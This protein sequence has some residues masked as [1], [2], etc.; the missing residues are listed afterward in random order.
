MEIKE[1]KRKIHKRIRAAVI[2]TAILVGLFAGTRWFLKR[3]GGTYPKGVY[4][5][6]ALCQEAYTGTDT[7]PDPFID[8]SGN[9]VPAG[10]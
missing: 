5:P 3:T 8:S 6:I 9:C 2:A 7:N 10:T 1:N 4:Q